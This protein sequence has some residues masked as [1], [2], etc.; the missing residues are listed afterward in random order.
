MLHK[1]IPTRVEKPYHSHEQGLCCAYRNHDLPVRVRGDP[2]FRCQLLRYGLTESRQPSVRPVKGL[3][4][5]LC[6]RLSPK[7]HIKL[8]TISRILPE[9]VEY[10]NTVGY[11][12]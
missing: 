11:A 9:E 4:F 7:S 10:K 6:R 5:P 2:V 1:V 3:P 12:T 8:Y